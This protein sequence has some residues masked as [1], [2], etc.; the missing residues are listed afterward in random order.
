MIFHVF[1]A[2]WMVVVRRPLEAMAATVPFFLLLAIPILLNLKDIYTWVDPQGSVAAGLLE[3]HEVHLIEH[4]HSYL[5]VGW[6]IGRTFIYFIIAGFISWRLFGLS[7]R[8]DTSGDPALTQKQRNLGIGGLPLVALVVTFAAFDWVMSLSPT[9]FS[10]IFGVYYFAGSYWSTMAVLIIVTT[11][12]RG[13]DLYGQFVTAEHMHNL[14]KLLFAFTCFWAY[15]AFSQLLLIWIGNLPEEVTF[16][17]VRFSDGWAPWGV[18]LLFG[19]FVIPFAFL[20]SRDLKRSPTKLS[21]VAGWAL[22]VNLLDIYWLIMPAY[23]A[24][25]APFSI[26]LPLAWI[27]IG[28]IAIAIAI[29]KIR[30]HYTVP[31]KDPFLDVSVRYRQ[32]T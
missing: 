16:Y 2:K 26:W 5:N 23:D 22:L 31:I 12:A 25:H 11:M 24:K 27:G 17:T 19:H 20:L 6:F 29:W 18:A 4:K 3:A 9:W 28:G 32:P 8:Q 13:K 10:T 7:V 1:R 21:L 14:G 30:G 15:I